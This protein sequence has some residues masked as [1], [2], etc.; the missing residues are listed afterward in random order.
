MTLIA[1]PAQ[2][3]VVDAGALD[4]TCHVPGPRRGTSATSNVG[5][6]CPLTTP[7]EALGADAFALNLTF[8]SVALEELLT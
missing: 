1:V 7:L 2:V 3:R 8:E 4:A 6:S 5:L